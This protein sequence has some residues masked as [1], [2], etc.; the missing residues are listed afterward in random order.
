LF[1]PNLL[2]LAS[3]RKCF[4][5]VR[6]DFSTG[7]NGASE[8]WGFWV[9]PLNFALASQNSCWPSVHFCFERN[10]PDSLSDLNAEEKTGIEIWLRK[11]VRRR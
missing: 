6:L 10:K 11:V 3:W 9:L 8:C 7:A 4:I 5:L 1:S 2:E